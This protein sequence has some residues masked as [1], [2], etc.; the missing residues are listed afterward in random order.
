MPTINHTPPLNAARRQFTRD[1]AQLTTDVA[2]SATAILS[3]FSD[4]DGNI[5]DRRTVLLQIGSLI[6]DLFTGPDNRTAYSETIQTLPLSPY[7]RILNRAIATAVLG[8]VEAHRKFLD[9]VLPDDIKL[10]L[11]GTRREPISEQGPGHD[12]DGPLFPL[13][14]PITGTVPTPSNLSAATRQF[15]Q[16]Y[17]NIRIFEPNPLA[18]YDPFHRWID[19]RG[20]QL[21]DRIWQV[22]VRTRSQIDALLTDS[23]NRG[24]SAMSIARDLEQ[25]LRPDRANLRTQRPYGVDASFDAMRL[26]RTEIT[27]AHSTA[28]LLSARQNPY[29]EGM[30][31][32]L[33]PS[34]PKIDI[35]DSF[36]TVDGS[37]GRIRDAYPIDE[38]V[39]TPV[40]DTHPHCLCTLRP[41]VREIAAVTNELRFAMQDARRIH[42]EPHITPINAQ[43]FATALLSDYLVRQF[44][45]FLNPAA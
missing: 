34:H 1:Y 9:R 8:V 35:C 14:D 23:I 32:A 30:D 26:A 3:R 11:M 44:L 13:P 20:Y 22:G 4:Q 5:T 19:P 42:I 6:D 41:T 40:I 15:L 16:R 27:R 24:R 2:T 38:F 31:Y 37:G 43:A 17:R 29:V 10:W 25:F 18:D 39:P 28:A 21:S 36:A 12:D 7:A 33:S 45:S